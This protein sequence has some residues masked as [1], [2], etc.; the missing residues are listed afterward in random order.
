MG[1]I[2]QKSAINVVPQPIARFQISDNT[3][4]AGSTVL[5]SN[6]SGGQQPL[7]YL[8]DFGDGFIST[9]A[10][11]THIYQAPGVYDVHLF[12]TGQ[13]GQS[14]AVQSVTVGLLP[15]ADFVIGDAAD[16]GS[17]IQGQAF[18]DETVTSVRWDMG[19][20]SEHEGQ[21]ID[22]VYWSAGDYPVTVTVANEFG[23]VRMQRSVRVSPGP[24]FLY[25]PLAMKVTNGNP[26]SEPALPAPTEPV[27]QENAIVSEELP[28]LDLPQDLSLTDQLLAYINEARRL[29]GAG[30]LN[31]VPEL[32]SAAQSHADDMAANGFTSHTG[33]DGSVP[34]LRVQL[35]GYPGGYAGE[36]TAWGMSDAIE[37]VR[38]W[39]TSPGHRV[40][41][42]NPAA[43]E[44]GVAF[45]E[46]Y[47][48]PSVWYWTAEFASM[49]LPVIRVPLPSHITPPPEPVL[50][51]L[52]PPTSGEFTLSADTNLIFTWSWPL[53]LDPGERFAVYLNSQGRRVQI[54]TVTEPQSGDQYQFTTSAGSV[55]ALP[56]L[57]QWYVRLENT[58][59]GA[60]SE[61][62]ES[63]PILFISEP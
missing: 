62:S 53:P 55:P 39:L 8:W 5:F 52:G 22:H 16:A 59:T 3:P 51:L 25:L 47:N 2:T 18:H 41:L 32:S 21:V 4:A 45:S 61:Q 46:N 58:S 15:V 34:A 23:E 27:P 20:G 50:T 28:V 38:Y 31:L 54:G 9:D 36:A 7:S 1:V 60:H 48:A 19:D 26:D 63:R 37:P 24:L 6:E 40:I 17:R 30:P 57:Q 13:N 14:E 12:L 35:S 49:D 11:P 33:S 44:V 10:N 42:L 29:N 43:T 56:G